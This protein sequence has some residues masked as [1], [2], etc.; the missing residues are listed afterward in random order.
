MWLSLGAF[1]LLVACGG[2]SNNSSHT[3]GN[4]VQPIAVDGGPV[5]GQLYPNGAFTSVTIC[6]PGSSNCQTVGGILVDTGSVGLRVLA[7][8]IPGLNLPQMTANSNNLFD[9]VSF[10]DGSFLW[11]PLVQADVKMAGETASGAG[12]HLIQDPTGFAVPT[13][14]S[15]GGSD[16]D[17]QKA[18]GANGILGVGP[19]PQDCGPA[20][21][22]SR[23]GTPPP[24]YFSCTSKGSCQTAFVSIDQ[25]VVQPVVKFAGDNNGVV[26]QFP[27]VNGV[28]GT[29]SG[30]LIFGI[31]TQSNNQ[32][33]HATIF[34]LNN[35]D[36]FTTKFNGQTLGTSFV[37]SGSNALFF[38]DSSIPQC[39]SNSIAPGFFCPPAL[40]NLSAQNVGSNNVSSTVNFSVDNAVNLFNS[41]NGAAAYKNLA[42]PNFGGT[43][44]PQNQN[45]C[46]F[47]W[48]LP[49]FYGRTVFA[50]IDGQAPPTGAPSSPWWAY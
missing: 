39:P 10:I 38:P 7:S 12:V 15:N 14:C 42:G 28:T 8:A 32:L 18:L 25:Q 34:T 33:G 43:C 11:G 31:G 46:S 35:F 4:N 47:D 26:L 50:S 6:A 20:C 9:C 30:S 3:N 5:V 1:A 36:N 17:S 2:S 48:G 19:E 37:D 45:A 27:A 44:S 24:V 13:A 29:L 41:N 40:V 16:A 22:P 21:D 49:F 23:G